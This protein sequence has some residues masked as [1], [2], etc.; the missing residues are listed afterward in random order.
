[1]ILAAALVAA[2]PLFDVDRGLIRAFI[3]VGRHSFGFQQRAGIEMNHAFGVKS[4]AIF[5][6]CGMSGIAAAEIFRRRFVDPR[7][8]FVAAEPRR[9]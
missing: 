2:Q 4:E 6:D 7:R 8:L 9:Y 5:A 1:M 3:S